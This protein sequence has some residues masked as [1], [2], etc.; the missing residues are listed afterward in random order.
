MKEPAPNI[1]PHVLRH[2]FCTNMIKMGINIKELQ[3]LMGH[4]CCSV[5]LD[6]YS[7]ASVS[8]IG[9]KFK[10]MQSSPPDNYTK[11]YT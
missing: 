10:I 6:V 3:Y 5:T 2:T 7:H 1:T 9:Q 4:S 8:E 11:H